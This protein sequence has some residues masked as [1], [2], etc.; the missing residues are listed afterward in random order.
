VDDLMA[1]YHCNLEQV[2][3]KVVEY[4]PQP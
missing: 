2:F 3:L 4:Q 1:R